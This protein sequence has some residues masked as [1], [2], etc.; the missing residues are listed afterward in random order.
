M[1]PAGRFHQGNPRSIPTCRAGPTGCAPWV[2]SAGLGI[3]THMAADQ[4]ANLTIADLAAPEFD[5]SRAAFV[6]VCR[7]YL[8]PPAP[9]APRPRRP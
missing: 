5:V 2:K 7:A 9:D 3:L 4:R 6:P 8:V 1:P